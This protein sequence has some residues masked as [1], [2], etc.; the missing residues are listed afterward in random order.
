MNT[1]AGWHSDPENPGQ[2]RYWDGKQWTEHRSTAVQAVEAPRTGLTTTQLLIGVV[3]GVIL[4]CGGGCLASAALFASGSSDTQSK[5]ATATTPTPA[6]SDL[7]SKGLSPDEVIAQAVRGDQDHP[8]TVSPGKAF[9]IRGFEYQPGWS[10]KKDMFG[11]AINGLK[12][13]NMRDVADSAWVEFK[14]WRGKEVL[15][16]A[17]CT[18]DDI[19]P[20]TTVSLDCG[21]TDD[22]PASYDR[23]TINDTF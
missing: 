1:P 15:A 23:L 13:K 5:S 10:V 6:V 22:L 7:P 20:G 14:F 11:F 18:S 21:S 9:D 16:Q 2:L 19:A 4:L 8:F 12:V 3:L 17:D